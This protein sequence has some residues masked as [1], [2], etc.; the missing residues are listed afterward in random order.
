MYFQVHNGHDRALTSRSH[1]AWGIGAARELLTL[2]DEREIVARA[3]DLVVELVRVPA[4]GWLRADGET[5][6]LFAVAGIERD[7]LEIRKRVAGRVGWSPGLRLDLRARFAGMAGM[8][9]ERVQVFG[10]SDVLVLV[11]E[12]DEQDGSTIAAIAETAEEAVGRLREE[13]ASEADRA[14]V[15]EGLAWL[16]HELRAPL[17]ATLNAID[18]MLST[19]RLPT[20]ERARLRQVHAEIDSAVR[21]M[22]PMLSVAAGA[23]MRTRPSGVAELI[24]SVAASASFEAGGPGRVQVSAE[25]ELVAD[26][27]PELIRPAFTNVI[28][29]AL[30]YSPSTTPVDVRARADDGH[31]V[32]EVRDRGPGLSPAERVAIFDRFVRGAVGRNR[33]G[34]GL[35]LFIA[36]RMV[37]AHGGT[38]DVES[39]EGAG[40]MFTIRIPAA[41]RARSLRPA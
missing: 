9:A 41:G 14:D 35:G 6:E 33:R 19:A 16:A 31:V 34:A 40:T 37:E 27:D 18:A 36:R 30:A 7:R 3:T 39:E 1:V 17:I 23:P 11:P 32:V 20:E 4:A 26:V 25:P 22:A 38:V 10:E 5:G 12:V 13:A 15:D 29:N 24:D 2:R 21:M 28:R 8:D